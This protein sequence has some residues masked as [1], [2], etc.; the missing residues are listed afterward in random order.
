MRR[1]H[2]S[3]AA[4]TVLLLATP[5]L[6]ASAQGRSG[7]SRTTESAEPRRGYEGWAGNGRRTFYCSYYRVPNRTCDRRGCRV[8][9]WSLTQTC[10]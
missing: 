2:L 7:W 8:T 6:D 9:S 3:L 1:T 5:A 4:L 10:G